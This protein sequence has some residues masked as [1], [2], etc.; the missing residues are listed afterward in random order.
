MNISLCVKR[1]SEVGEQ[2]EKW[3][4]GT[5]FAAALLHDGLFEGQALCELH[6]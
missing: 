3:R 1:S 6:Q 4:A 5:L 2:I